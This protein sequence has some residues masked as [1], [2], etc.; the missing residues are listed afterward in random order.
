MSVKENINLDRV[1]NE[2]K[3][4]VGFAI[5]RMKFLRKLE[6]KRQEPKVKKEEPLQVI[7]SKLSSAFDSFKKFVKNL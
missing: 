1:L 5:L 3:S 6:P 7:V 2:L 4:L